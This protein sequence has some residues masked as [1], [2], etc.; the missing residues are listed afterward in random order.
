MI[1]ALDLEEY[2]NYFNLSKG[3]GCLREQDNI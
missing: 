3:K 2:A 1:R